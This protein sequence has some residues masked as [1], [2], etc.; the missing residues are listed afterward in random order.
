M[1]Y[2]ELAED[3]LKQAATHGATGAEVLIVEEESSSVQVRM[4]DVDRVQTAR[5]K[6]LGLRV[7]F[8]PRSAG[9]ATSDFSADSLRRLL[10]D[11]AAMAQAVAEDPA[12][13]LPDATAFRDGSPELEMWDGEAGSLPMPERIRL[14]MRAEAAAL[15]LDPR[16]VNSE[17]AEFVHHD[18]S[19][20][21][22]NSHGFVGQYRGSRVALSVVPVAEEGGAKQRDGWSEVE[23]RLAAL[24]PP[25]AVGRR[26]AE[27]T[28]RR[29]GGRPVPTREV[30][31]VL[32]PEIAG[33]LLRSIAGAVSGPSLYRGASFLHGM[34][35]RRVAAAGVGVVDDGRLPGR[36][37]SRPFDGEGIPTRRTVVIEDGVLRS[38]LLDTYSAR[39]LGLASTGNA[40]RTLGQ[41]PTVGPT[42]LSMLPGPHT[43]EAILASVRSGLYVT[44]LIGFGVNLVTGDYSRGAAGLW[45]EEGRLAYPVEEVTIAG[46]L[47]DMLTGI[48][49]VGN[50][51]TWRGSIGAPTIKIGRMTVA[52]T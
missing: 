11:T 29:L 39:K 23:R 31:V 9:T 13:G 26:A 6:R 3:L 45:I 19:V 16:I 1:D 52:G 4:R 28:L 41:P 24:P 50:D 8:G 40:A 48:E 27:R 2:R 5:E 42:N 7:G 34:L 18:A 51:L 22:A 35:D 38:Y 21:I 17:G 32:E 44:E 46:N 36:V 33:S 47:R 43:P 49:M 12:S 14:A 15:D 20:L 25:E 37:G 30:P 10:D